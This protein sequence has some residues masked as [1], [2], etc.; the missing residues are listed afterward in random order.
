LGTATGAG[1]IVMLF[2]ADNLLE[3]LGTSRPAQFLGDISYSFYLIHLPILLA[4]TSALYPLTGSALFSIAVSLACS[5]PVA[6]AI[7]VMVEI[8]GQ[9]WGKGI[10]RSFSKRGLALAARSAS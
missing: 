5:L 10:A 4:I 8:P 1:I 3:R 7:Y 9:N 2:L 6:W